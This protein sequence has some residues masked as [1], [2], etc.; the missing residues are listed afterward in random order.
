MSTDG[1]EK[2]RKYHEQ[3]ARTARVNSFNLGFM[4]FVYVMVFV[5]LITRVLKGQISWIPVIIIS[6]Y[7]IINIAVLIVIKNKKT[8]LELFRYVMTIGYSILYSYLIFDIKD[9]YAALTL[10]ILLVCGIIYYDVKYIRIFSIYICF[11]NL[12]KVVVFVSQGV[13]EARMVEISNLLLIIMFTLGISLA[14]KIGDEFI[15]DTVGAVMDQKKNTDEILK[16]VLTISSTVQNN[17]ET[18]SKFITDLNDKMNIVDITISEIAESTGISA[19]NIIDQTQM[20]QEIQQDINAT[21]QFTKDVVAIADQSTTVIHGSLESFYQ[22]KG[23]SGDIEHINHSVADAMQQLQEKTKNVHEIVSVILNISSRTNLLALNASIEAARAGESGKGFAVVAEEIRE[24]AEQTR[25]S[26][27]NIS[28]ILAELDK[29]A[30][31]ASDIVRQ[32]IDITSSQGTL[33]G[34]VSGNMDQVYSKMS[35]L[36]T[37]VSDISTRLTEVAVSNQ[38]IVDNITQLSSVFEEITASTESASVITTEGSGLIEDAVELIDGVLE[39][40]HRLD[41][42]QN[43]LK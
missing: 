14:V 32:S 12:A 1:L 30:E 5:N 11:I 35:E 31:Y 21:K 20:T 2:A 36:S 26:T 38:K 34:E 9:F 24:L 18:T 7:S 19:Q 29:N 23:Y 6:V 39:A 10:V 17:A 37:H 3:E 40:S 43:N 4:V 27:A 16:N 33:I 42:Y 22:L 13:G 15:K 25:S 8:S 28:S 41:Q